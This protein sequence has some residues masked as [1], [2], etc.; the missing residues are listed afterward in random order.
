MRFLLIL[1]LATT[2]QASDLIR[3]RGR[4]RLIGVPVESSST[5]AHRMRLEG[6][7]SKFCIGNTASGIAIT[8]QLDAPGPWWLCYSITETAAGIRLRYRCVESRDLARPR[9]QACRR[10]ATWE[11][12]LDDPT[13]GQVVCAVLRRNGIDPNPP[14]IPDSSIVSVDASLIRQLI[15]QLDGDFRQ[16]RAAFNHLWEMPE[17]LD[18][19]SE[20]ELSVNQRVMM[21]RVAA[22]WVV[23]GKC[24]RATE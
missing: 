17:A 11:A 15:A 24:N 3:D 1:L 21:E 20:M 8:M 22:R 10:Y 23:V 4:L 5:G 9:W 18:V 19:A 14:E 2:A 13:Y 6:E 12:L 16:R 7:A